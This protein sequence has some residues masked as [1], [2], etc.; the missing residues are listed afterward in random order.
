MN[1]PSRFKL[2]DAKRIVE[3]IRERLTSPIFKKKVISMLLDA[4]DIEDDEFMGRAIWEKVVGDLISCA[5]AYLEPLSAVVNYA[6][7]LFKSETLVGTW[8]TQA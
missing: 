6:D 8:K 4:N 5:D 1:K 3:M 2:P 7:P